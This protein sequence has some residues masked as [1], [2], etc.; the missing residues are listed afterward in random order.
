MRGQQRMR[1]GRDGNF[2]HHSAQVR[3]DGVGLPGMEPHKRA[4]GQPAQG[5]RF[6]R[7]PRHDRLQGAKTAASVARPYAEPVADVGNRASSSCAWP[8]IA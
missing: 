8:E 6:D 1:H 5:R 4:G 2:L 3:A 7:R